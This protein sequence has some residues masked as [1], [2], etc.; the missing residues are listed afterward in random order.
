[1][2]VT[3]SVPTIDELRTQAAR[4]GVFPADEDL[5]RAQAFLA[6][7]LPAFAKLEEL[8]PADTVPAGMYLP[9]DAP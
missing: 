4:Q 7:L 8:V 5:E 2:R 1:M 3:E 6:V 9:T